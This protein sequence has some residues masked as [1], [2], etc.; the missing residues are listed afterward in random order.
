MSS[1]LEIWQNTPSTFTVFLVNSSGAAVTGVAKATVTPWLAK[2]GVSAFAEVDSSEFDWTELD[3]GLYRFTINATG[4]AANLLDTRGILTVVLTDNQVSPDFVNYPAELVVVSMPSWELL[5]RVLGLSQHNY[6]LTS[7]TTDGSG[8]M[9]TATLEI[10]SDSGLTDLIASYS[11]N[12]S[13]ISGVVDTYT[14]T[15]D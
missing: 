4:V 14:S 2:P 9:E 8:H 12:V 15:E 3:F 13:Y 1:P 5:P 6:K 7:L 10:Y 11:I